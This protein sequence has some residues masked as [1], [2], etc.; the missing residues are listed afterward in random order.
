MTTYP[1]VAFLALQPRRG[2]RSVSAS[3]NGSSTSASPTLTILSRH[4]GHC[5]PL[6]A[7]TSASTLTSHLT[8]QLL[9]RVLP[10]LERIR[11]TARERERDRMLREEQDRAFRDSARRDRERIQEKM[12][13]ERR[14]VEEGR[15]REEEERQEKERLESERLEAKRKEAVKMEWRRWSR[16]TLVKPETR[17]A[18]GTIRLAIRLPG[19]D[20]RTIR[21]FSPDDTLTSLYIYVDSQLI[22]SNLS[23]SSDPA[24]PPSGTL[25]GEAAIE[26]QIHS[27]QLETEDTRKAA[28]DAWWDFKLVLAYPRRELAWAPH[29]TLGSIDGLKGGTQIVVEMIGNG[30]SKERGGSASPRGVGTASPTGITAQNDDDEYDTESD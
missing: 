16:R 26:S 14:K 8:S 23:P 22:P 27:P 30:K 7:P 25:T 13:E 21:Q 9:P 12:E 20:G 18:T 4:Q 29:T 24:T 11:T 19:G 10:F 6:T 1:F 2:T 28:A 15:R 3:A 5:T 17:G